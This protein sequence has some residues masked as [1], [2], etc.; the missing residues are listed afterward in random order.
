MFRQRLVA[1]I[2]SILSVVFVVVVGSFLTGA[3]S[4]DGQHAVQAQNHQG[5]ISNLSVSSPDTGQLVVTWSAP[6]ETPTDYRVRWAPSGQDYL[7]YSE[8][9]TSETR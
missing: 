1:K 4:L 5:A 9:N 8:S 3:L 6:G 7:S 2:L